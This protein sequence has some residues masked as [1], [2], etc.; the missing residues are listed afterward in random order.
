MGLEEQAVGAQRQMLRPGGRLF[1][2]VFVLDAMLPAHLRQVFPQQFAGL[3]VQQT[4]VPEIPL[5]LHPPADPSRRRAV[6][7]GI[8]FHAA[9]Q[10][11][12]ALAI[13]A[14]AER[15]DGQR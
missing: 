14:V 8:H 3:R 9:I 6:V 4:N 13:L 2:A 12:R 11:H 1:G 5:H 10:I 7:G 15:L